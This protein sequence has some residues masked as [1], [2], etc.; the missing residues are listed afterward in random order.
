MFEK[1]LMEHQG[2]LTKQAK[3]VNT[4]LD[5]FNNLKVSLTTKIEGLKSDKKKLEDKKIKLQEEYNQICNSMGDLDHRIDLQEK[6]LIISLSNI[7]KKAEQSKLN[8]FPL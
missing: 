4:L 2:N 6:D 5:E 8:V 3:I 7:K 1:N